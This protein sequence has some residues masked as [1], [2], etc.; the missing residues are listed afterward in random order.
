M[1]KHKR[2]KA[3]GSNQARQKIS[4]TNEK[5]AWEILLHD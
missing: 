5:I 1:T 4:H 2:T 3:G